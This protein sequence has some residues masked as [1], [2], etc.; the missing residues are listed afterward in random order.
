VILSTPSV[1]SSASR[2]MNRVAAKIVPKNTRLLA[3]DDA[4]NVTWTSF[5]RAPRGRQRHRLSSEASA[6]SFW[7]TAAVC[8]S[9]V[10]A[11]IPGITR[12]GVIVVVGVVSGLN[13]EAAARFSYLL[14]T[15]V[16]LVA[17][18]VEVPKH[19]HHGTPHTLEV[20]VFGGL[21]VGV[22]PPHLDRRADVVPHAGDRSPCP[23]RLLLCGRRS[24]RPLPSTCRLVSRPIIPRSSA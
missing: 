3:P 12:S 24:R 10:L 8:A 5:Q 17:G 11:L 6:L 15:P 7:Q 4:T 16:I 9:Q 20:A 23:L 18:I 14:A 2:H 13:A 21:V 19:L 1:N 22:D